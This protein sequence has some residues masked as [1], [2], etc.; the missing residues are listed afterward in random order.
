VCSFPG[1]TVAFARI[2]P[3]IVLRRFDCFRS[4]S[5]EET[6]STVP[7]STTP[8]DGNRWQFVQLSPTAYGSTLNEGRLQLT[9]T[10]AINHSERDEPNRSTRGPADFVRLALRPSG[11]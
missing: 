10:I 1:W 11:R 3:D 5:L 7:S 8:N 9:V 6:G 4:W 2:S